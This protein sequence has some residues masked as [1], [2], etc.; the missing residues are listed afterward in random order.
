MMLTAVE[1]PTDP[2][3]ALKVTRAWPAGT[4]TELGTVI[5]ALLLE[6][7]T[8]A[9]PVGATVFNV[10]VPTTVPP[11]FTVGLAKVTEFIRAV[12]TEIWAVSVSNPAAVAVTVARVSA[13][14]LSEVTSTLAEVAPSGTTIEAGAG[15]AALLLANVT[16][17]PPNGAGVVSVTL[18][19]AFAPP[20]TVAGKVRLIASPNLKAYA[21]PLKLV[22]PVAPT[23]A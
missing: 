23:R 10:T 16:V 9:P 6:S 3:V 11:A 15:K 22:S 7:E 18:R 2:A 4:S 17:V 12:F 14:T 13:A 21:A 5:A 20:F 1:D 19:L 8:V